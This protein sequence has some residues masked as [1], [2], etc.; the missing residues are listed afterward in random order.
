MLQRLPFFKRLRNSGRP[1]NSRRTARKRPPILEE[2]EQRCLPASFYVSP[3]GDDGDRGTSP[4]RAWQSIAR[5]NLEDFDPGD[6]LLFEGGASFLGT[7]Q[8]DA[9]DA[10]TAADPVTISS[11]GPGRALIFSHIWDGVAARNAG[12]IVISDLNFLGAGASVSTNGGIYVVNDLPGDVVLERIEVSNVEI[13]GYG[14]YGIFIHGNRDSSGYR[15]VRITRAKVHH[16]LLGGVAASGPLEPPPGTF[17]RVI[18]DLYI[19]YVESYENAGS[20][21]GTGNGIALSGVE[22]GLIE[23]SLAHDNGSAGDYTAGF[24]TQVAN[25]V[26]FQHNE[27]YRNQSGAGTS[28]GDGFALDWGTTNSVLQYNYSHDN[29]GAG[30]AIFGAPDDGRGYPPTR[31]NVIRFNI[32]ENDARRNDYG[33]ISVMGAPIFDTEVYNNTV[34][35][36]GQPGLRPPAVKVA[37]WSGS[38]LH[39]RNNI[40]QTTN[41]AVLVEAVLNVEG[42]DL[43]FQGN[44]YYA[45]GGWPIFLTTSGFFLRLEDWRAASGQEMV[46]DQPVGLDVDPELT[47]PGG[48]GTVGDPTLLTGL[49]AYQL[50]STSP[51]RNAGLDLRALFGID[52]G[53]R[54]FY[55]NSIPQGSGYSIGAHDRT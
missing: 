41:S 54:D 47:S 22:G 51:L 3:Q 23:Y 8:L 46:G 16:N 55:G 53:T 21:P 42:T 24:F 6:R 37:I 1:R 45:T 32:S 15:D 30:F 14:T 20:Q 26:V 29:D 35:V 38:G 11:Y 36:T 2:L 13:A 50:R 48:G 40:F 52:P 44:V 18:H 27:S 49:S 5:A 39:F 33:A 34:F 12:G 17:P 10:G 28:D 43:V 25:N 7:I 31:N 4:G 9:T 19:G